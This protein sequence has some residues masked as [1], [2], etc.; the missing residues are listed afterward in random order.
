MVNRMYPPSLE[1]IQCTL[2]AI[3]VATVT[4]TVANQARNRDYCAGALGAL[5]AVAIAY[6]L[7]WPD[8]RQDIRAAVG[9]S[10]W[11]MV[12][13]STVALLDGRTQ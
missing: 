13:A 6:S 12:D 2:L 11:G 3:A 7:D 8:I 1:N 10:A 4:T 9:P 5:Q